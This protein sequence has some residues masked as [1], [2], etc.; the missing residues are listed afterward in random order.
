MDKGIAIV[1]SVVNN[2]VQSL[3]R[4]NNTLPGANGLAITKNTEWQMKISKGLRRTIMVIVLS[5]VYANNFQ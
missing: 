1:A 3:T 2:F 5:L 4:A